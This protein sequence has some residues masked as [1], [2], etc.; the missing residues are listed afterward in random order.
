MEVIKWR[1][2][3]PEIEDTWEKENKDIYLVYD[4]YDP[5]YYFIC[6]ACK[7]EQFESFEEIGG[8]R[9]QY[10]ADKHEGASYI[11]IDRDIE[12]REGIT[13]YGK[14]YLKKKKK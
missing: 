7:V 9:Y 14:K 11:K 8:G 12:R 13:S 5:P 2:H 4:P 10:I 1:K 6:N 3:F